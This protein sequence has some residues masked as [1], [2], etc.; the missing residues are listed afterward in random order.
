MD[1]MNST[2]NLM[3]RLDHLEAELNQLKEQHEMF[4]NY[5]SNL[6]HDIRTPLNAIIGFAGLLA[7][8][9]VT[10][11]E[12]VFYSKMIR[13]SSRKLLTLVSNLVD[14]AKLET[15][16]L[17]I[18]PQEINLIEM[19]EDLEDEML[20]ERTIYDKDHLRLVVE[21]PSNGLSTL[22]SDRARLFQI[23]K[24]LFDNALKYTNQGEIFLGVKQE[25]GHGLSIVLKDTGIGMDRETLDHLFDLFPGGHLLPG[26]KVK[27]RGLG[28]LVVKR[29]TEKM[30]GDLTVTSTPGKGT[31]VSLLFH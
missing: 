8:P 6:S 10:K 12:Q 4:P 9:G 16:N 22:E 5:L 28:M 17:I 15:G 14:L 31:E 2:A 18:F 19:F 20:E 26:T 13:R 27:S 1:A 23:L 24:I 25:P 7:E 11:K 29:L 3:A 30:Q 21:L